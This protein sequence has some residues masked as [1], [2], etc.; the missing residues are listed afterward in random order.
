MSSE[1]ENFT[2]VKSIDEEFTRTNYHLN[3]HG[4]TEQDVIQREQDM[5]AMCEAYPKLNIG[6]AE[7]IWNYV[8]R[9]GAEKIQ[10]NIKNGIYDQ[11]STK[12]L[13]GGIIQSGRIYDKDEEDPLELLKGE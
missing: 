9:T 12:Y 5:K 4:L 7:L 10:E 13:S 2:P 6:H 1:M 11:K 8:H 3:A